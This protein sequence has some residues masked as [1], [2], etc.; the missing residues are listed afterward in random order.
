MNPLTRESPLPA[1]P[2][3]SA[4]RCSRIAPARRARGLR[5]AHRERGARRRVE[6]GAH[7]IVGDVARKEDIH[8][9][10]LQ[11][12]ASLGGLDVLVN[13]ASS[14]GPTPLA[15]LADTECEDF[16]LALE[17]N[18]LGPFRLTSALLGAL[19]A[20][21]REGAAPWCSTSRATRR[22]TLIARW[23]AYGA[24]KAALRHMSA[25]WGEELAAEG[26]RFLS[27]DPGDMDTPLHAAAVPDADPAT[28]KRPETAA[29]ELADAVASSLQGMIAASQA[30][31]RPRDARLL[32][33]DQRGTVLHAARASLPELLRPGDL[34]VANDA[35][36]LPASLHGVQ[37]PSGAP[38]EVRL[39]GRSSLSPRRPQVLGGRVRRGRLAHAHRRSG[40]AAA[41]R[42][43]RP[44]HARTAR[45]DHRGSARPS[46]TRG[47]ELRRP[48]R[49][50]VGRRRAAWA[51]DPV[52][53]LERGA[54]ALGRL[55][56]DRRPPGRLRAA[57][58]GLRA[59]LA[60]PRALRARGI[61][62]ATLTLAAGISSTGDPALDAR[63]PLDEAY[64]IPESTASAIHRATTKSGRIVAVGT[65]VVRALEHA[66]ARSG[67]IAAGDGVA[68]QRIDA[69]TRLRVVDAILSG[70][71]EPQESHYQLLR[72]FQDDATL[73]RASA[74]LEARGYRTHEFG[75]SVLVFEATG[76][77]AAGRSS[78][79]RA[80][81]RRDA[82]TRQGADSAPRKAAGRGRAAPPL[83]CPRRA[84]AT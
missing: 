70:T 15:L 45:R 8:P 80:A 38:I 25:I 49:H 30:L 55:D 77:S 10:A 56:A 68:T 54:R 14:L 50:G 24:S 61:G 2:R 29:R 39:A 21:A 22:S 13:N 72:A 63:L 28:L 27:L 19:T 81:P 64:R 6:P 33:V 34:V 31:Q 71:H 16:A 78:R 7:G 35:A 12:T 20:S 36:T 84:A 65:T 57:V 43:R 79:S 3:A 75:D 83:P 1:A 73:A 53:V 58:G 48:S 40:L 76:A 74:A 62:F 26:V 17:T 4:S 11:M 44:S 60:H 69:H 67:A 82:S 51:A 59:R 52:R 42:A 18:V 37:V 66:A 32:V 9:I 47:T 41:A 5:R 46:A 23:G